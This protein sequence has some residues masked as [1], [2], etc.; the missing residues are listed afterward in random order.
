MKVIVTY[1]GGKDSQASLLWTL[2][3][4]TRHPLAVFCN[5]GWEHPLTYQHIEE[6]PSALGLE[7]LTLQSKKYEGLAELSERKKKLAVHPRPV[8]QRRWPLSLTNGS[9][10]PP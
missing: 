10:L 9:R 5:T 7:L 1:S 4:I 6:T 8:L 3:N 2:N